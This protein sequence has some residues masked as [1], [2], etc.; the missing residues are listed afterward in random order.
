MHTSIEAKD[1]D[2]LVFNINKAKNKVRKLSQ[3]VLKQRGRRFSVTR[4]NKQ[5][6]SFQVSF[7]RNNLTPKKTPKVTQLDDSVSSE[8]ET[9]QDVQNSHAHNASNLKLPNLE[10]NRDLYTFKRNSMMPQKLSGKKS[11]FDLGPMPRHSQMIKMRQK[12]RDR[13]KSGGESDKNIKSTNRQSSIKEENINAKSGRKV[14]F[15]SLRSKSSPL[16]KSKER[17]SQ[18]AHKNSPNIDDHGN[19]SNIFL[20]K[21]KH[22]P[23]INI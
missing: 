6:V 13:S 3:N 9:S 7:D 10:V 16:S 15:D 23:N 12:T 4:N 20:C 19:F 17:L 11:I 22:I 21:K 8:D 1:R 18:F 2:F 14:N 5:N